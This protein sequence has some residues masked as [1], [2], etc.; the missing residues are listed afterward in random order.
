LQVNNRQFK[1]AAQNF[2]WRD[3]GAY[4][5][6][7]SATQLRGIVQYGLVGHSERRHVFHESDKDIRAK[8]QAAIRN[9]IKPVLCV[10][11]TAFER[12]EG[13]TQAV[14]HDQLIGGLANVTSEELE[15]IT[16]AYEPVW[17]IG[18]GQNALPTDVSAAVR[19]I[20]SQ[21][22]HLFGSSAADNI[23]VLYGGSVTTDSAASY[24]D[25]PDVDGL[26]IGGASLDAHV[27]SDIVKKAHKGSTP[28]KK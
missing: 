17:A 10:G 13:E 27:F 7:I 11:E 6:E 2:Y 9:H 22:K 8:V 21:I 5:G 18:T 15:D 20:R 23:Q 24:L 16:I 12:S 3:M 25:L 14:L 19:S 1:L 28:A 26:L 4:T